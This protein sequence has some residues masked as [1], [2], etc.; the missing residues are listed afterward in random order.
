MSFRRL[1]GALKGDLHD[2]RAIC[3]FGNLGSLIADT[4]IDK[5]KRR[6][7]CNAL[8]MEHH[9]RVLRLVCALL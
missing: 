9:V 7:G 2:S 3:E 8:S 5:C 6:K 1:K 4:S